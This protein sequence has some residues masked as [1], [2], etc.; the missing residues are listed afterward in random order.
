MKFEWDPRKEKINIKKHKV[1]FEEAA[2]VFSDKHALS[3]FDSEHSEDEERWVL[4]GKSLKAMML[5]VVHTFREKDGTEVVRI[6]SA[7]K[8]TK[9]EQNAYEKRC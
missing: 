6:I 3:L 2:Y 4:L 8:A 9:N 5:V 1:S 7:R